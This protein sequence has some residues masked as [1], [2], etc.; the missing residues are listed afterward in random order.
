M[1]IRVPVNGLISQ[2]FT[3][4]RW[5]RRLAMETAGTKINPDD[6]AVALTLGFIV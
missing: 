4:N 6:T 5:V 1:Y 2:E 3:N